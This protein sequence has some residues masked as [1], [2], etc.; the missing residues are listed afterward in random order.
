[1]ILITRGN[2]RTSGCNDADAP[3][4]DALRKRKNLGILIRCSMARNECGQL[5][6]IK[7]TTFSILSAQSHISLIRH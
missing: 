4:D 6:M 5:T 7:D 2:V 3:V 1:M